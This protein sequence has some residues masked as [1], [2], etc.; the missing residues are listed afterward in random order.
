M[1]ASGTLGE[2]ASEFQYNFLKSGGLPLVLSMLTRNNFLPNADMETRRGRLPERPEN[3]QAAADGR[4]VR[5]RQGGG[6]GLPARR[7][8]DQPRVAG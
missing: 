7:G 4:G 6:R 3:R 1:P 8:G 2:E 5:P